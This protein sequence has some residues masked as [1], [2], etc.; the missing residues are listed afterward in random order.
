MAFSVADGTL[1]DISCSISKISCFDFKN[2][3]FNSASL[4]LAFSIAMA[5][6]FIKA[7]IAFVDTFFIYLVRNWKVPN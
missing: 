2:S 5:K 1:K 3:S 4:I 7:I 6:Y